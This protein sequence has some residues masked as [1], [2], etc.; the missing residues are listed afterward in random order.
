[1]TADAGA[2]NDGTVATPAADGPTIEEVDVDLPTRPVEK[3]WD[4]E[5]A[6]ERLRGALAAILL[7][8]LAAVIGLA[9]LALWADIATEPEIKDLLSVMLTPVVALVGSALG[10]YFGGKSATR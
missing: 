10:F 8:L 3:P 7:V 4:P 2:A 5:P 6:R 1:V 9:W